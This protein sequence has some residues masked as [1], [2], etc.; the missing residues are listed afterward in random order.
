MCQYTRGRGGKRKTP[1][2]NEK[3]KNDVV[4]PRVKETDDVRGGCGEIRKRES[5]RCLY[6]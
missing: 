4:F 6:G 3:S 2:E 1:E 5:A